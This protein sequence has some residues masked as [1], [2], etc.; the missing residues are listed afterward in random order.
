[1]D[2]AAERA[3]VAVEAA[4]GD[5]ATLRLGA[6]SDAESRELVTRLDAVV[7]RTQAA[8]LGAVRNLDARPAAVPGARASETAV[9]FL[10]T[11]LR[12]NRGKARADVRAA[13]VLDED[14]G[15]LPGLGRALAE[16]R[17]SRE[18]ADA[19]VRTLTRVPQHLLEAGDESGVR[20]A[21]RVDALLTD[22]ARRFSPSATDLLGRRLLDHLDPG[23]TD[24]FDPLAFQRRDVTVVTDSTGMVLLRAQ[25]DPIG[26]AAVKAVLDRFSAPLPA[27]VS[28]EEGGQPVLLPDL[29]SRGQRQADALVAVARAAAGASGPTAPPPATVLVTVATE[30]TDDG[31]V[32]L[33]G[34][35][36][37]THAG[38]VSGGRLDRL[39]CDA[40]LRRVLIA[41]DGGVL[42]VGRAQRLATVV[43]RNALAIRDGGCVIPGARCRPPHARRITWCTGPEA[44]SRI[45]RIWHSSA[46]DTTTPCTPGCGNWR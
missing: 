26:G 11:S 31:R 32:R 39:T 30:V 22:L 7:A 25:L 40:S 8:W 42:N 34:A 3:M 46:R 36:E 33:A 9:T 14:A 43:Q 2:S 38:P 21:E 4:L 15:E 27:A 5:L 19:G 44:V 18:H 28:A 45:W 6:V 16:G 20:G 1:M 12:K 41:P 23:R 24:R 17:V 35:G 37:A 13:Q 10:V 29:R